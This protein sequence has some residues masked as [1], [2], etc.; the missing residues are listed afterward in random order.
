M[1]KSTIETTVSALSGTLLWERA[2]SQ[3]STGCAI[4]AFFFDDPVAGDTPLWE[5]MVW[6]VC[7]LCNV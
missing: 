7:I 4:V 5:S 1:E 6:R 3:L 2:L